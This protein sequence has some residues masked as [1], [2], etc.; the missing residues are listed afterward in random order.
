MGMKRFPTHVR[1]PRPRHYDVAAAVIRQGGDVLM[2]R[3]ASFDHPGEDYW[4]FPAGKLEPGESFLQGVVR[5]VREETGLI[6]ST[7]T[8][9]VHTCEYSHEADMTTCLVA[10]YEF[11]AFQGIVE[12]QDPDHDILEARFMPL[13]DATSRIR[14]L[15]WRPIREPNLIY[16]TARAE[17]RILHWK[18]AAR[19]GRHYDL[20]SSTPHGPDFGKRF[21]A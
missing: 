13:A 20:I 7:P 19:S 1:A 5:E 10:M 15:T 17:D 18:Y 3:Q 12:P 14:A 8:A 2:V 4:T 11:D 21:L 9:L 6:V 16:L